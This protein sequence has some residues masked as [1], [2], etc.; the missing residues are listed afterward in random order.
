MTFAAESDLTVTLFT[1]LHFLFQFHLNLPY[2]ITFS[3]I[4]LQPI[5]R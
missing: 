5:Y 3:M 2:I 4:S 1:Y